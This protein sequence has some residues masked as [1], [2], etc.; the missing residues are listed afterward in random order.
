M[1]AIPAAVK[2]ELAT[3]F[4]VFTDGTVWSNDIDGRGYDLSCS[5]GQTD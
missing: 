5:G 2:S 4:A 1:K 3:F